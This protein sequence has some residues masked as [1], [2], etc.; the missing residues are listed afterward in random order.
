MSV[1]K[2]KQREEIMASLEVVQNGEEVIQKRPYTAIKIK[3]Y[4]KGTMYVGIGFS[5]VCWPDE[6]DEELGWSMAEYRAKKDIANQV[7]EK[8]K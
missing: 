4:Y 5:K 2:R 8:M 3:A 1:S 7:M 6:W